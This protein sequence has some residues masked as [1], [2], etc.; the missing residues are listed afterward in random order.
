MRKLTIIRGA[1]GSGKSTLAAAIWDQVKF[2]GTIGCFEADDFFEEP[3]GDYRYDAGFVPDAHMLCRAAV[4]KHLFHGGQAIVSNTFT[5]YWEVKPY[6]ELATRLSMF[7]VD[8]IHCLGEYQNVH[9]C[10]LEK[11][12]QMRYRAF[13][14]EQIEELAKVDFPFL[15]LNIKT[16]K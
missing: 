14:N 11:V 16:H 12:E 10:P 9:G 8:I 6:L 15:K 13:T 7:E 4:A 2:D 3:Y 1:P 5:K